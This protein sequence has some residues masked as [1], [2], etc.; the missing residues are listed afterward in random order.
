MS[1]DTA[2]F[3]SSVGPLSVLPERALET[4][5]SHLTSKTFPPGVMLAAQGKTKL[6]SFY[7][8]KTGLLETY[9]EDNNKKVLTLWLTPG[10]TYGGV[11][12]LNNDAI[13]IRSVMVKEAA[14]IYLLPAEIFR[15]ICAE[16]QPFY[17]YFVDTFA[18][19]MADE[20]YAARVTEGQAL[21]FLSG[22]APFSFLPEKAI[23]DAATQLSMVFYPKDTILFYQGTS[24]VENLYIVQRGAT[25]RYFEENGRKTMFS[26]IG[27]GEIFGGISLLVNKGRAVRSLRTVEDS[28]FFTLPAKVFFELCERYDIFADYFTNIFGKRMLDR[29]Y[30]SIIARSLKPGEEVVPFFDQPVNAI[31]TK[32]L[33]SCEAQTS[34]RQAAAEMSRHHCSSILVREPSGE[35]AGLVTDHDLREKVI[36]AGHDTARPVSDIISSPLKTISSQALI[37]EALLT[38]MHTN[39]KHLAVVDNGGKV[40]GMITNRDLVNAQTQ[41]PLFLIREIQSVDSSEEIMNKSAQQAKLIQGLMHSG[42]KAKNITR[43]ITTVSDAILDRIIGFVLQEMA[44]P[45]VRFAFMVMGSEG[46]REQTLK[47]DQD[48]AIVFKDISGK[49]NLKRA[50][51]YFRNF[52]ERVCG[53]LDQAGYAFCKGGVM[54]KNPKWCQPIS[55]WKNYFSSWIHTAEAKDLLD[56]SI[57]FDFRKGYGD[58]ALVEDLRR[59]LF[60]SLTGWSGFF[61]HLTE[62]ALHFKPPLGFFRN[63]VVESKGEHRDSLDL[64]AAM[65]P[66]V[67]IVRIYALKNRI[68]A[69]N[70]MER[71]DRL[72]QAGVL[73][74]ETYKEL[75]LAYGFLMQMRF[76]R[77]V[78]AVI[79]ENSTPD[80]YI[81]PK[82]LS[83]VERTMLKE[84]FKLIENYQTQ[85]SFEFTGSP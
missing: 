22:T 52:G 37:F 36:A 51:A 8:L 27:E 55:I 44:P 79:W 15:Q 20:A 16:H 66:I 83:P 61:R 70:T 14:S 62:N 85:I 67:D 7:I 84:I 29:S 41:S 18:K 43:L 75:D 31:L 28:C 5:H 10:D 76:S 54:A 65:M 25:E 53:L 45:P 71:L 69:T 2:T 72:H 13:S 39:V 48:N 4:I 80:N 17:N 9:F 35:Y 81:N 73:S 47:T 38:M 60:D 3:L 32:Q 11:S 19:R 1:V 42:A 34:I 40:L 74:Q 21:Q 56:S 68:E 6:E 30:A 78:N 63:F 24:S 46:R 57:F 26:L 33:V 77:Q 49:Q 59:H 23:E 12:I 64:K 50:M 82:K 58:A